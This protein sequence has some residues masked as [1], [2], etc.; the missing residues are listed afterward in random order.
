MILITK[1]YIFHLKHNQTMN[2][3]HNDRGKQQCELKDLS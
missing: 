1:I 3:K 2:S